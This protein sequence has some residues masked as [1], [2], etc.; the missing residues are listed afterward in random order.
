MLLKEVENFLLLLF[1]TKNRQAEGNTGDA[2]GR[3]LA[4]GVETFPAGGVVRGVVV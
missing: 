4:S 1:G 2:S 3:S